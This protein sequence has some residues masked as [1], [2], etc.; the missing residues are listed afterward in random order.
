[1]STHKK[2]LAQIEGQ[3]RGIERLIDDGASP[4]A[5]VTQIKAITSGLTTVAV[6]LIGEYLAGC[7]GRGAQK[8]LTEAAAAIRILG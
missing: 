7:T 2:R 3:V 8:K 1:M 4:V 6:T 5:I